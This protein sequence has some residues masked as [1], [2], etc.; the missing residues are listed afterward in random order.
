MPQTKTGAPP[1]A[2]PLAPFAVFVQFPFVVIV[3][4]PRSP[5]FVPF[6]SVP[7]RGSVPGPGSPGRCSGPSIGFKSVKIML[8]PNLRSGA[9]FAAFVRSVRPVAVRLAVASL[10][11]GSNVVSGFSPSASP[12]PRFRS[13][14]T[15]FRTALRRRRLSSR[16]TTRFRPPV[17]LVCCSFRSWFVSRSSVLV[18]LVQ[19]SSNHLVRSLVHSVRFRSFSFRFEL[20]SL[21]APVR[22]RVLYISR[23]Y[24][25]L[26][27]AKTKCIFCRKTCAFYELALFLMKKLKNQARRSVFF[28]VSL[29]R[30][31]P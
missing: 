8:S 26:K 12:S 23:V 28:G 9:A 10:P 29:S 15:Q 19:F 27:Q 4:L 18:P 13:A 5:A 24:Y 1:G 7:P 6:A 20:I 11:L 22:V 17:P 2:F 16:F 31:T 30:N 3:C 21:C 25:T 14:S